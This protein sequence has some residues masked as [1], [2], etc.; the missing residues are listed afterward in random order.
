M[1]CP[2]CNEEIKDGSIICPYCGNK[3]EE[4]IEDKKEDKKWGLV[5]GCSAIISALIV[6]L[7]H[8]QIPI[9][10]FLLIYIGVFV[11]VF[12]FLSIIYIIF[13]K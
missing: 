7:I 6:L 5:I 13:R 9:K 4:E 10:K 8:S 1:K 3:V 2:K 11:V 12:L